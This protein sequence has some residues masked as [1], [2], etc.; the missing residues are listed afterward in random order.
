MLQGAP[1]RSREKTFKQFLEHFTFY[2]VIE[3]LKNLH[4]FSVLL[5]WRFE[6]K[7]TIAPAATELFGFATGRLPVSADTGAAW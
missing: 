2:F 6:S 1:T 4:Y 5:P 3:E 7:R